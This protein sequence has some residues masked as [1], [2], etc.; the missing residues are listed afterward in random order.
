MS[1]LSLA[2][3]SEIENGLRHGDS[4]RA[5]ADR[6]KVARSTV[7]REVKKHAQ[8]SNKGAKGRVTNR[9]IH[10]SQ[11]DRHFLCGTCNRPLRNRKCSSCHHCNE[12]C[13][14]FVE[15]KC[16]RLA[17]PPYVC[18]GCTR[19]GICVLR[20]KFYIAA[21]AQEA[22][23]KLLVS[24]RE[25]A[26][27]TDAERREMSDT[28]AA[29]F[30]KGQSLH[31]IVQ[32]SPDLFHVSERTLYKYVNSGLLTPVGR[33]D[34]PMAVKMKPRR[35]KGVAHK[36]DR[37]CREGRTLADFSAFMAARPGLGVVE[38]DSVEGEKGGKV[39]LTLNFNSC[40]FMMAFIREANTSQSV[41]DI[42]N[43]LEKTFGLELFRKLFPA[44]ITDNG[45]EFS[46]PAALEASLR[47][48]ER[49][50]NIFYCEPMASWQKPHV[51]NNH[52]NLR[53]IFPRGASMDHVTQEKAAL[54][55]SHLNSKLREGLDDIQAI[56][57]FETIYGKGVLEKLGVRLI[58]PQDVN[59]APELV[60]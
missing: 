35:R 10:R 17:R 5:I 38:M 44:I 30:K 14:D 8:E 27:V 22:Y 50:T 4:F 45:S 23:R 40:T 2:D 48:G 20:K 3:R 36:V 39:L 57:L 37:K 58:A 18:N 55:M 42:F 24:A 19:E 49:R 56:K 54:A 33:I 11:C 29:G 31:H 25:G 60:K 53:A 21:A 59:L 26:A 34:L 15:I 9:C 32:A 43:F 28:L 7:M 41:I 12:V 51:E 52:R 16:E 1:H 6:L 13:P 47:D 46:N